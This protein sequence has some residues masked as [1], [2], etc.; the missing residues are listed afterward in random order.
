MEYNIGSLKRR[1]QEIA[2]ETRKGANTAERVGKLFYDIVS[3]IERVY[4]K[5]KQRN[6]ILSYFA[7]VLSAISLILSFVKSD[8]ITVD[9]ANLLGCIIGVL[10]VLVTILIGYQIYKT[11]EIENIIDKKMDSIESRMYESLKD[12]A[13]RI[14]EEKIKEIGIEKRVKDIMEEIKK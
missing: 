14:T 3:E 13:S 11:I 6:F 8:D 1:S 5:T 7:V 9:G 2:D 4:K 10:A 12:L